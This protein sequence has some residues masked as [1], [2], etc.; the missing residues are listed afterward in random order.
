MQRF[1]NG[2]GFFSEKVSR[3]YYI[4]LS[5]HQVICVKRH[6]GI[7]DCLVSILASVMYCIDVKSG[8]FGNFHARADDFS[9]MTEVL[10]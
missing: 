1:C 2:Q 7:L 4:D 8:H 9:L 6:P 3:H 10:L 5:K